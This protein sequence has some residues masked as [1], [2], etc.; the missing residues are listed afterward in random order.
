M[1]LGRTEVPNLYAESLFAYTNNPMAGAMRG[2]GVPQIAFAHESQMDL[3]AE[4]LG[5][6]PLEIRL[7]N[8]YRIG[9]ST[10]TRQ[11]LKQVWA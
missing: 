11:N 5:I 3:V 1:P 8:C 4:A 10:S 2:F 9:F 7:R 6:S